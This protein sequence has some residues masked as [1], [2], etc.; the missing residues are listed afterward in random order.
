MT[1]GERIKSIRKINKLNQS[2]FS[3]MIGISQGTLSE[4]ET[5]KYN[6]SL[7]TILSIK[8]NFEVNLEWLLFDV[9]EK[10]HTEAFISRL[11]NNELELISNFRNLHTGDKR[12]V[13]EIMKLKINH[14][15]ET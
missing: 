3:N 2:E 14:Y 15:K 8:L 6:P 5:D 9:T 4:L 12:E 11:D 7:E 13:I 1:L 10:E